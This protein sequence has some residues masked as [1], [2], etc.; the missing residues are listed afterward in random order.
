MVWRAAKYYLKYKLLLHSLFKKNDQTFYFS[1]EMFTK[2]PKSDLCP[3]FLL[4]LLK[5]FKF[6]STF[7]TKVPPRPPLPTHM[8][9]ATCLHAI[10]CSNKTGHETKNALYLN[11][12]LHGK[13]RLVRGRVLHQQTFN[14]A[15]SM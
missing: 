5:K 12:I 11:E 6:C 15:S 1:P 4:K 7:C 10:V 2:L 14:S 8:S 3:R 13:P 9:S